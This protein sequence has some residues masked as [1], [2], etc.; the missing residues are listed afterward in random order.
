MKILVNSILNKN[1]FFKADFLTAARVVK[2]NQAAPLSCANMQRRKVGSVLVTFFVLKYSTIP[3]KFKKSV[4]AVTT[5]TG[6][7]PFFGNT[8]CFIFLGRNC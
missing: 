4:T 2:T 7:N 5:V 3:N 8:S 6:V 1:K